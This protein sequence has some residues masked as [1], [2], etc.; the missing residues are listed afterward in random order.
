M[1]KEET[2]IEVKVDVEKC[3]MTTAALDG[4]SLTEREV[5]T[6]VWFNVISAAQGHRAAAPV[7]SCQSLPKRSPWGRL[8]SALYTCNRLHRLRRRFKHFWPISLSRPL[9]LAI[10]WP[11]F[12]SRALGEH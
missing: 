1:A 10:F 5:L 12:A 9:G 8:G 2:S 11:W 3:E 6:L 4:D 7:E